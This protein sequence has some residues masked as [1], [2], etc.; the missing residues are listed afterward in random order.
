MRAEQRQNESRVSAFLGGC[1]GV[2]AAALL[3]LALPVSARLL[4]STDHIG[5][6]GAAVAVPRAA[7]PQQALHTIT[8]TAAGGL[9]P[10]EPGGCPPIAAPLKL[11][12]APQRAD[13][14][15]LPAS[16]ARVNSRPPLRVLLC[17]WLN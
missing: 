3:T 1:V 14:A 9:R 2:L 8:T 4:A 6:D 16:V 11:T 10:A 12:D 15:G 17:R 13:G 5:A 7:A